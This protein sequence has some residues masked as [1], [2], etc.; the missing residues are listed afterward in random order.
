MT[1]SDRNTYIREAMADNRRR[2]MGTIEA[3]QHLIE[4]E[5]IDLIAIN[6]ETPNADRTR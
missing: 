2:L 1:S 6:R 4:R 5:G 3:L